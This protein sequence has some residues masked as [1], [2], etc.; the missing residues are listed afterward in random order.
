MVIDH[1]PTVIC[2]AGDCVLADRGFLIEE[3]LATWGA[4]LRIPDF[5]WGKTQM[6]AKDVDMSRQIAYVQMHVEQ[7]IGQLK[8]FCIL[9]SVIPISS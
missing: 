7:V 3:E 1:W 8:K 2:S 9:N 5:T 6:S 4:A